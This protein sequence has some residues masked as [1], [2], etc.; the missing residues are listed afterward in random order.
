MG[1][2]GRWCGVAVVA[3]TGVSALVGCSSRTAEVA[4]VAEPSLVQRVLGDGGSWDRRRAEV[5]AAVAACMDDAGWAY[6]PVPV[7]ETLPAEEFQRRYGYGVTTFVGG[8]AEESPDASADD[9]NVP[10][11]NSLSDEDRMR[12]YDALYGPAPDPGAAPAEPGGCQAWAVRSVYGDAFFDDRTITARLEEL[13]AR[14]ARDPRIRT[15]QQ[16]WR[17]CMGRRGYDV[18]DPDAIV[19]GLQARLDALGAEAVA[20]GSDALRLL[21]K[22]ELAIAAADLACHAEHV[23]PVEAE[24]RRELEARF[25]DENPDLRDALE[26]LAD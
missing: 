9:P 24:V 12:W 26:R 4:L 14:I 10:Y 13:E 23:A 6:V 16:G 8:A 22:D 1:V 18:D 2:A 7:P 20:L 25:L 21:Q 15:A 5:E 11:V 19:A 3:V 17:S